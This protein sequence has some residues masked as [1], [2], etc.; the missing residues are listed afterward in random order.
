MIMNDVMKIKA[1]MTIKTAMT[2]NAVKAAN[3]GESRQDYVAE[4][5]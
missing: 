4:V 2:T 1:T 5:C 3:S